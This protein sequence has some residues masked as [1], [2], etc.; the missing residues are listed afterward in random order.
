LNL[1]TKTLAFFQLVRFPNLFTAV[2][3]VLA[4]YLIVAGHNSEWLEMTALMV[5]SSTIYAGGC[6]LND[7]YDRELDARERPF[8]PIPS[9]RVSVKD[10]WLM[11]FLL[12]GGG[13]FFSFV[14]GRV[15]FVVAAILVF[16]VMLYDTHTKGRQTI[17]PLNMAVCRSLNLVLGMS[18][19][20][21]LVGKAAIF[22][23]I[24][25]LYVFSLTILS[26]FEVDEGLGRRSWIVVSGWFAVVLSLLTLKQG[27]IFLKDSLVFL[28]AFILFTGSAILFALIDS[29]EGAIGRSVRNL[30]LGIVLLDA[31]Y[32]SGIGGWVCGVMV[33]LCVLPAL[34]LSR[35]FYVT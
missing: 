11:V 26:R 24:T 25:L 13:L 35:Y 15:P 7:L 33:L 32:C 5:S 21:F 1:K 14:V 17:G 10:A 31:V 16:S 34:F 2:A 30:I 19:A 12:F 9:G 23:F 3:D 22:P 8:R 18:P 4:G 28:I 20:L 6:V 29:R 27:G